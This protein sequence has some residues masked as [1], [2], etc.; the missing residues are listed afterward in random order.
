MN[1]SIRNAVLTLAVSAIASVGVAEAGSNTKFKRKIRAKIADIQENINALDD[2]VATLESSINSEPSQDFS[3]FTV[4]FA[5]D[6]AQK[7]VVLQSELRADGGQNYF[8]RSRYANSTELVSVNGAL[9]VRPFIANYAFVSTDSSGNITFVSNYIEAP[10]T[11]DYINF[12][13]ES[14]TYDPVSLTK[15]VTNDT[16]REEWKC[17]SNAGGANVQC[18]FTGLLSASGNHS[19]T[20]DWSYVRNII[21]GPFTLGSGLTFTQ[22]LRIENYTSVRYSNSSVRLRAKGIGEI[23]RLNRDSSGNTSERNAIYYYANGETGG[24]LTGTPFEP[25]QPLD[26]LFF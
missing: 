2:R 1:K 8:V 24:S 15:T 5:A 4:P 3:G 21:E 20:G 10:D 9:T 26:G 17:A 19:Y 11:E 23:Y 12:D 16:I 18:I 22:D 14:S 6:G 13:T 25:G 7:N